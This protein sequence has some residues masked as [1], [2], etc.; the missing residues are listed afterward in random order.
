MAIAVGEQIPDVELRMMTDQGA[1][2]ISSR[3]ALGNGTV[4]L[5][6]VPGAFTKTCSEV[7]LPGFVLRAEDLSGKGVDKIACIAVNDAAVMDAW[8]KSQHATDSILMLG[9]GNADFARAMGLENDFSAAGMGVRSQRYAAV[10]KDG[11]VTYLGVE[12]APGVNKSSAEAVLA[13][14]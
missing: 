7:H 13:A 6:A 5:F 4:V 2:P 9:D 11:V 14:L 10:L 12:D 8:G 1:K 3:E